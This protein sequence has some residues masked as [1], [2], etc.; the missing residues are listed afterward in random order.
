M[1]R[2][3][4]STPPGSQQCSAKLA[5]LAPCII[6]VFSG[7]TLPPRTWKEGSLALKKQRTMETWGKPG[8]W[9]SFGCH[10]K[11]SNSIVSVTRWKVFPA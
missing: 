1:M 6:P 3:A 2:G 9:G 5:A 10:F 8:V 11:N 7:I 4:L